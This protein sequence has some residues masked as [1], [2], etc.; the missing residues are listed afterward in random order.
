M[1]KKII[2]GLSI[3]SW[4]FFLGG[5]YMVST[6]EKT[7]AKLNEIIMLHQVEILRERLLIQIKRV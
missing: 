3:F 7:T 6:I 1:K 2:I 5:I 4:I